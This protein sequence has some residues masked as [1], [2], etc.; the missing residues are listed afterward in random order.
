MS[1]H[2][3]RSWPAILV[4]GLAIFAKENIAAQQSPT[5]PAPSTS[6]SQ[7][8][9]QRELNRLND[10]LAEVRR[11]QLNYKIERDLLKNAYTSSFQTINLVLTMILGAFAVLGY[12]GL[13]GLGTL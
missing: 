2:H 7:A 3:R 5:S 13:R 10:A 1:L 6:N 11:D 9:E 8:D 12:L 4:F